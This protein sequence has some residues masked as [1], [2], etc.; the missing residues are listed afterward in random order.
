MK[1]ILSAVFLLV[2]V[3]CFF[4]G[5]YNI[6]NLWKFR[7]KEKELH[8][9]I[10]TSEKERGQLTTEIEMLKNDSTYIEKVA[11]EKFKMGKPDE[12]IYVVQSKDEDK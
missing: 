9:K 11:R 7:H 6:Y 12:K 2:L 10:Q 8:S 4:G 5:D 3:Y 1:K